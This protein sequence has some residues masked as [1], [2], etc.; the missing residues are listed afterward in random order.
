M[1][2]SKHHKVGQVTVEQCRK[3]F[4]GRAFARDKAEL[5]ESF[6]EKGANVPFFVDAHTR[7]H[8]TLAERRYRVCFRKFRILHSRLSVLFEENV[9]ASRSGRKCGIAE[10]ST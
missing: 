4:G 7:R 10:P 8:L 9:L 5:I 2:H 1:R 6:C 3:L